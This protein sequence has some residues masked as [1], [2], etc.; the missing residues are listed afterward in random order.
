MA[1]I[2]YWNKVNGDW[3]INIIFACDER[4]PLFQIVLHQKEKV[5]FV[6]DDMLPI[7]CID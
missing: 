6:E 4:D 7:H 3:E 1:N 5:V 2:S